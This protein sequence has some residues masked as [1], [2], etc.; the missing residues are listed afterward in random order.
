VLL[1]LLLLASAALLGTGAG[2]QTPGAAAA[3]P[4]PVLTVSDPQI[5]PCG[6]I[7]ATGAAFKP[8][9]EIAVSVSGQA[10]PDKVFSDAA[11]EFTFETTV[12]CDQL[13]GV[14]PV[15]AD[16]GATSIAVQVAIVAPKATTTV[17]AADAASG[18]TAAGSSG[19]DRWAVPA[20]RAVLLV[21]M[22][23]E[24]VVL[25]RWRARLEGQQDHVGHDRGTS[26]HVVPHGVGDG[27]GHR[28][29][30]GPD[31]RLAHSA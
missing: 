11:G 4:T 18:P 6:T 20:A 21:I 27:V 23:I 3:H 13:S 15:Q 2:A 7:T 28:T 26:E 9:A 17:V 22:A 24:L 5:A 12:K 30:A 8:T 10:L 1:G 31:G 29:E 14:V 16:D 25:V 19:F